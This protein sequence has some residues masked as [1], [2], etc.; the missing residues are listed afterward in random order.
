MFIVDVDTVL[1]GGVLVAK[2]VHFSEICIIVMKVGRVW[3]I[4]VCVWEGVL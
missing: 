1:S 2:E 3:G 4:R